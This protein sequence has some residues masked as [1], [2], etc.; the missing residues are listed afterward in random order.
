MDDSNYWLGFNLV[1]GI[2]PAKLQALLDYFGDLGAAW[3]ATEAQLQ[4]IGLD[5]RAICRVAGSARNS[6][7]GP[8]C[9]PRGSRR[10]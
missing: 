7:F 9:G 6:R 2:G 1:K 8:L 4:R 5:R 3:Q 10:N